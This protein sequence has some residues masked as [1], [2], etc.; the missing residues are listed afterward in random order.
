MT[1]QNNQKGINISE[2]ATP[3]IIVDVDIVENNIK[4]MQHFANDNIIYLKSK[5]Y[6]EL[7]LI[8]EALNCLSYLKEHFPNSDYNN[9]VN[10]DIEK[11]YNV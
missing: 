3:S 10:F 4:K 11:R 8:S 1:I 5:I 9:I 7:N 6:I 2:I